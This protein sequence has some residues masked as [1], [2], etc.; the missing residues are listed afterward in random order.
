MCII[1]FS[2]PSPYGHSPPDYVVACPDSVDF[3]ERFPDGSQTFQRTDVTFSGTTSEY[4][5]LIQACLLHTQDC[6]GYS[7]FKAPPDWCGGAPPVTHPNPVACC[8]SCIKAGGFC[9]MGGATGCVC[10]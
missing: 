6:S 1:N 2:C 8:R 5:D 9:T 10:Q 7:T 4:D 3:Y